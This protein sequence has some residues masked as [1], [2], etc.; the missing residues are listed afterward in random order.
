M[1]KK[2]VRNMKVCGQSGY[3]YKT[4]PSIMLKGQWLKDWG[5]CD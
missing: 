3:Q 5:L 2:S 4:I 1:A